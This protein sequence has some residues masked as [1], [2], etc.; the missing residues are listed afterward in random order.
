MVVPQTD[1]HAL[2]GHP[3]PAVLLGS[4]E[5][6]TA[7]SSSPSLLENKSE[8]QGVAGKDE[9]R[10]LSGRGAWTLGQA[11]ERSVTV[12]GPIAAS[13][14]ST[15]S[16]SSLPEM[17]SLLRDELK[18]EREARQGLEQELRAALSRLTL[19]EEQLAQIRAAGT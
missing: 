17:I 10:K 3:G 5:Q 12:N 16:A 14:D 6:R 13:E 15:S 7:L 2:G 1:I 8:Q 4:S 11:R 19:V 9:S 18:Q